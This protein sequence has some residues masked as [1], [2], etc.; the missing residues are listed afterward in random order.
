MSC[1]PVSKTMLPS[2]DVLKALPESALA[3]LACDC[4]ATGDVQAMRNLVEAGVKVNCGTPYDKRTPL[5]LAAAAGRLEMIQFL[6]EKCG[7][8]L[9]RDRFGLL[10]INDAVEHG[11]MEVRRY[12]QSKKLREEYP[13]TRGRKRTMSFEFSTEPLQSALPVT[14]EIVMEEVMSTVFELAVKEGVFS[15][16]TVH[17][18]VQYFFR[19]LNLHPVYFHHFTPYQI[20]KH[21]H[22]LIAAKRVARATEDVGR[23]EFVFRSENAGFFLSSI[24]DASPTEAQQ[25][26]ED[27]VARYINESASV[28]AG[29]YSISLI[30]MASEGPA[31]EGGKERLGI[32]S[33]EKAVFYAKKEA[34]AE[35]ETSLDLLA[36]VRFLKEKSRQAREQ[37]Q[38]IMEEV[39]T[40]RKAVVRVT[41]GDTFQGSCKGGFVVLFGTAETAGRHYFQ[42]I[43]QSV[44]FAGLAPR[45]FYMETFL[46]GVVIYSL[47][48]PSAQEKEVRLLERTMMH[49][50]LLKAFPGR[51]ALIYNSVMSSKISHEVGLY[52]MAG[53]RFV[54]AFF[55]R[56]QY[57]REYTSVHKV[58]EQDPSSQRKL[59]SLYKL[60]MK[61]LLSTERIYDL[62][63]R[64]PELAIKFFEDFKRIATGEAQPSFNEDLAKVI[65]HCCAD[66]QDR[67]ILRM[68]LT[69][70]HSLRLTNFFKAETPGAF[71]F[72]LDPAVALK[73]RPVSLFPEVPYG[74]YM[75]CGRDFFGFHTRFRDVARGGIRLIF[76][77]DRDTYERNFA[78]L[79]DECYNL[80]FTQNNKNKD[81]PEGGSKGVILP[82]S[83][84]NESSVRGNRLVGNSTQSPAAAKSCFTRYINALLDCM[85]PKQNG[86]FDGHLNG[87]E[88]LLFFGPDEN[89]AGF[90]DLGAKIAQER[91]YRYWKAL[92]TGKSVKLGGVPHDTYGMTT[93][94]VH[95]YVVELLKA[96]GEDES[97]ITKFQT[98]G[99]D[100]DLGSNEILVSK[101]KTVGIVDGSGVLYDPAGLDRAELLKLAKRR[102]TVKHFS[103]AAIGE[104]GFL[105]T[106]EQTDVTLPDGTTYAHGAHLRD[107]F[108]LSHYATA[109][110]FVPCGGRPNSV[111]TDNVKA[112]FL[113]DGRPKFRMIVEGANLFLSEDARAVLE[114]AGVHLFKDASTNKG[115]VSSSSLEVLAALALNEEDHTS[116][117]TYDPQGGLSEP[118]EFYNQYVSEILKIIEDNAKLEFNAIWK[119]NQEDNLPKVEATKRLSAQINAMTDN[120]QTQFVAMSESERRR[121]TRAALEKAL[122]P[123]IVSHLGVDGIEKNVPSNY[124]RSIVASWVASRYVYK[125]G[126]NASEVSFFFFM[127][128]LLDTE[129]QEGSGKRSAEEESGASEAPSATKAR[130]A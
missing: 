106:V 98:G 50:T 15:Y 23:M 28:E 33:A 20:A 35:G 123:L 116:L 90:M 70:N 117:L 49:S 75:I 25:R 127:R 82:D 26:T 62:A 67:Q 109:D 102:Q 57:A 13:T 55:P 94:S 69:F 61:E 124:I 74:I 104:G 97:K 85:M 58:L 18:E 27:K 118:P 34:L 130:T 53:V 8:S 72:R 68:F 65:D 92:T 24:G 126:I 100:G 37:Y 48:F 119:A 56:E 51:S 78:T 105:V 38:I 17:S 6:V 59:E 115:G 112:L 9:Q 16:S 39:V 122:P 113:P 43:S 36:S 110:L 2:Q 60:C 120:I 101:D 108:H 45:R 41:S 64:I 44:R 47:F 46:N 128:S 111:T 7:A 1:S 77:R 114:K 76:S 107:T 88:E 71:A 93:C 3:G 5:H 42:E 81:I 19:D 80:A 103:R 86:I 40:A 21:I 31:F 29:I 30:F 129:N 99:P 79:F 121:L 125:Y 91:S 73:N 63:T 11:H 84:H 89:T 14:N 4:A 32:W 22:C 10:P 87:K 95:T 12:L 52:L 66:A 96:L 83:A 54:F